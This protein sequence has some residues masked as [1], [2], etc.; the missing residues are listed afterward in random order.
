MS[1]AS[2]DQGVGSGIEGE[3][4]P[5][6]TG[7]NPDWNYYYSCDP[8]RSNL[9]SE[10]GGPQDRVISQPKALL[11]I[12]DQVTEPSEKALP[13]DSICTTCGG[14]EAAG[15]DY[16]DLHSGCV[17]RA[18]SQPD[19]AGRRNR[20][21]TGHR[22]QDDPVIDLQTRRASRFGGQRAGTCA[23]VDHHPERP[24]AADRHIDE[25]IAIHNR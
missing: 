13:E 2:H 15:F 14:A 23:R 1:P 4:P 16:Q 25:S 9:G 6:L 17:Y 21:L 22:L 10:A 5:S 18:N 11:P 12:V 19:V 8:F 3:S 20:P 7:A 24:L